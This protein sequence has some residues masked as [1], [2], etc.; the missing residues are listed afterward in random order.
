ML[1]REAM[2]KPEQPKN[3]ARRGKTQ[4]SATSRRLSADSSIQGSVIHL[5][6]ADVHLA[7]KC[8]N[9]GVRKKDTWHR[10]M[11]FSY[12]QFCLEQ[13]AINLFF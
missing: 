1:I 13:N 4:P 2:I 8:D 12:I 9:E 11:S 5:T 7:Q 6:H 10:G 3:T